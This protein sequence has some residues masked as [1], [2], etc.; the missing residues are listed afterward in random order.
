MT[1][2]TVEMSWHASSEKRWRGGGVWSPLV[3]GS[4]GL[5]PGT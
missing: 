2:S 3:E 5:M 1:C 4:A